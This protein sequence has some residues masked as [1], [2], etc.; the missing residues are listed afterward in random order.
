MLVGPAMA[1][2][3]KM[4]LPPRLVI[5]VV[6]G[7]RADQALAALSQGSEHPPGAQHLLDGDETLEVGKG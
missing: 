3:L 5:A 6:D 7:T 2:T 4:S 1:S